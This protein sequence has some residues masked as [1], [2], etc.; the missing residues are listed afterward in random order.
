MG[1]V[2]PYTMMGL[3]PTGATRVTLEVIIP[4]P[5]GLTPEKWKQT[6]TLC[7]L[8][9]P[10]NYS[11]LRLS[12]IICSGVHISPMKLGAL[13]S[14]FCDGCMDDFHCSAN[15][16]KRHYR[17]L[18]LLGGYLVQWPLRHSCQQRMDDLGPL[19]CGLMHKYIWEDAER[20]KF[21]GPW[22]CTVLYF[23]AHEG[24]H[25][26]SISM[27]HWMSWWIIHFGM[28]LSVTQWSDRC[29]PW[30]ILFVGVFVWALAPFVCLVC[31][32]SLWRNANL[33]GG[34]A[35]RLAGLC[36]FWFVV[37]CLHFRTFWVFVQ[38]TFLLLLLM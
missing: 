13:H 6:A 3:Q 35:G 11:L 22:P 18:P 5:T 8:D 34:F 21:V 20:G 36:G 31:C 12:S 15:L 7:P 1:A 17:M 14:L 19:H 37:I 33:A 38:M 30:Q 32:S 24:M 16:P 25:D 27:F 28:F 29:V 9:W 4:S 23:Y 26:V 2:E 10:S